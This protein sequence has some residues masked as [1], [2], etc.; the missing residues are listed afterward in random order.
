MPI[1]AAS[2][3]PIAAYDPIPEGAII[4]LSTLNTGELSIRAN[5]GNMNTIG[6]QFYFLDVDGRSGLIFYHHGSDL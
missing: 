1:L 5:T 4:D 3:T 2:N 6:F